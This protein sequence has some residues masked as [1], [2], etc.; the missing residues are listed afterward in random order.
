MSLVVIAGA[1]RPKTAGH[2]AS[3]P[4]ADDADVRTGARTVFRD[5]R[6]RLSPP[7]EVELG[8]DRADVV[9]HRLV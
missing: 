3:E 4:L 2:V 9:L 7:F 5:E 8:Q 6:G 1:E